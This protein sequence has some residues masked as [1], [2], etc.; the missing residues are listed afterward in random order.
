MAK[1]VYLRHNRRPELL[2]AGASA[3]STSWIQSERQ[4]EDR[5]GYTTVTPEFI[6]F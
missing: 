2:S 1:L 3:A 4:Q 6:A 5:T